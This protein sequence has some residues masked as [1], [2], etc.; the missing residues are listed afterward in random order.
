MNILGINSFF[1]HPSVALV[2]DGELVFAI[3]DE[4]L[5]RIKNGKFY[6]PYTAYLPY[7]S[8]YAAL[9]YT[10]LRAS[11]I[12]EISYSYNR[13]RHLVASITG[14]LRGS[15]IKSLTQEMSAYV[16]IRNFRREMIE[17]HALKM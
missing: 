6:S 2:V 1:E 4:R 13:H 7:D 11:S 8:I 10:G 9:R 16:T 12:D 3:E 17:N 14:S 15:R 5:T